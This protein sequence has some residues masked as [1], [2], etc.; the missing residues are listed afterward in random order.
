ML[1]KGVNHSCLIILLLND[2]ALF[3]KMTKMFQSSWA[4]C[5]GQSFRRHFVAPVRAAE[6]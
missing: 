5:G 4:S 1:K 2:A 6:V 3:N